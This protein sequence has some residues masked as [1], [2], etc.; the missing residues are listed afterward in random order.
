MLDQVPE[1]PP[2]LPQSRA[3]IARSINSPA[4]AAAAV[5]T[6]VHELVH[7]LT[8]IGLPGAGPGGVPAV[9][10]LHVRF[11]GNVPAAGDDGI[12]PSRLA[13]VTFGDLET[14][15]HAATALTAIRRMTE[16]VNMATGPRHCRTRWWF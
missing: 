6:Q 5:V 16:G 4:A 7:R 11:V 13:C 1:P 3:Q 10:G 9:G 2:S 14:A 15:R 8:C 12:T